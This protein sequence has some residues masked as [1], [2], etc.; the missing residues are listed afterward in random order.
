MFD[1]GCWLVIVFEVVVIGAGVL[2]DAGV[3]MCSVVGKDRFPYASGM[4]I[5]E[6]SGGLLLSLRQVGKRWLSTRSRGSI[7]FDPMLHSRACAITG[8]RAFSGLTLEIWWCGEVWWKCAWRS[9]G[10]CLEIERVVG[11]G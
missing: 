6:G 7:C 2:V 9:R 5:L 10:A 11:V 3:L 1:E 8:F 4:G